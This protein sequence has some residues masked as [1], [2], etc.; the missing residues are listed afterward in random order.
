ML[1]NS[2]IEL[3]SKMSTKRSSLIGL[4]IIVNNNNNKDG[5]GR[6]IFVLYRGLLVSSVGGRT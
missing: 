2:V 5:V 1:E 4:L 3:L 6:E